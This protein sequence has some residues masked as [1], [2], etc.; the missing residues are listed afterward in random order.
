MPTRT[1]FLEALDIESFC[2][3]KNPLIRWTFSEPLLG[4]FFK[5]QFLSKLWTISNARIFYITTLFLKS[6]EHSK[7]VAFFFLLISFWWKSQYN[8]KDRTWLLI[9][10]KIKF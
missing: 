1:L 2:K 10:D 6:T 9:S 8:G 4:S 5:F 3:N 7:R